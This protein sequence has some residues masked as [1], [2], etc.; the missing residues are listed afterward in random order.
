MF[1]TYY[2][3]FYF[4][5]YMK[6]FRTLISFLLFYLFYIA[7]FLHFYFIYLST[8]LLLFFICIKKCGIVFLEIQS[9]AKKLYT[10]QYIYLLKCI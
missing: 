8:F 3:L 6:R 7:R 2:Y 10:L 1:F 9:L 4:I 5:D